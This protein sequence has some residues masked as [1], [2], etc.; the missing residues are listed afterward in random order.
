MLSVTLSGKQYYNL[1]YVKLLGKKHFNLIIQVSKKE[2]LAYGDK[3]ELQGQYKKPNKQRNYGGYD[4]SSYLKTLKVIGRVKTKK[5]KVLAKKQLN[6]ILQ[7]ANAQKLKMEKKIEDTFEEEKANL[8]KGILLGETKGIQEELKAN[9]Q[10]ANISHILAISGMHISY[11]MLGI[12][13]VFQKLI[14]KKKSLIL[15]SNILIFYTFITGFSPSIVRAVIMGIISIGG[16]ILYRKNDVATSISISLLGML[17]YNPFLLF[18]AGMQLSYIGTIGIILL[19]PTILKILEGKKIKTKKEIVQKIKEIVAVSLS[20]QIAILPILLYHFNTM[21]I[22]FLLTNLLVSVAIGPTIIL[23]FFSI[24]VKVFSI[25]VKVGLTFLIFISNFSQFPCSKIYMTT[26]SVVSIICY[27][28]VVLFSYL[29]YHIYK[30]KRPT[31]TQKR[32]KNMI[33]LFRYRWRQKKKKYFPVIIIVLFLIFFSFSI[34]PKNLKIYFVDVGQGDCT[35]L[36]TPKNKTILIDGGGSIASDFDVGKK[37]VIPYLLD[38]G[39]TKLDYIIVSHFDLDH[40]AGLLSVM[41]ELTVKNVIISKQKED[42]KQYQEFLKLVKEKNMAVVIV[43]K[44]D[45]LSLENG[46]YFE[47]LWPQDDLIEKKALNNNSIVAKLHYN[48]FSMLFTGDIEEP[49]EKL[50]LEKKFNLKAD[51]LKVAHHRF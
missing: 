17:I 18:H 26:P 13:I 19:Q 42:S 20:T 41:E 29:T 46:I 11:L 2:E 8:L 35:F 31:T 21:G 34:F 10:T 22:Y 51:I 3:I 50:L 38:R 9:F 24:F 49:A 28:L 16:K 12:Q 7:L 37:T 27:F 33:A 23:G 30:E 1:Y 44:G 15:T 14:G 32:F 25:P 4:D 36:V 47:F 48:Q 6:P 5:I 39:Y 43:K 45:R 40:V